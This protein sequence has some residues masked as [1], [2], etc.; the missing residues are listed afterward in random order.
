LKRAVAILTLLIF[1]GC[2]PV[3][4]KKVLDEVERD[5]TISMVQAMPEA[6]TGRKILWGGII[7]KVE[8]LA[9]STIIEILQTRLGPGYRPTGRVLTAGGGRF[10]ISSPGYLD[11]FVYS[12]RKRITVAGI[13]RG[14]RLQ[15][16]GDANY[17]YPVVEPIEMHLFEEV[18]ERAYPPEAPP[19]WYYPPYG[20]YYWPR[21]PW[22][23]PPP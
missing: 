10:L 9:D 11:A 5:I 6:Y 4:S 8:N 13:I 15:K 3:I 20:P 19:W 14:I 17:P 7:I 22:W 18:V 21:Y 12:P 1:G 23:H 16:I 2:A